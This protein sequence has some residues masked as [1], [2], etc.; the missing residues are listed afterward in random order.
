MD[1]GLRTQDSGLD[2]ALAI[3]LGG[4]RFRVAAV[5][6]EGRI[7]ERSDHLTQ[8]EAAPEVVIAE[9]SA[10]V[11]EISGR[12]GSAH[13]LGLG[14]AAPG[15]LDP[16][17]G[18]VYW[19]PNLP[20]WVN[21]PLTKL[22]SAATGLPV[23]VGNDANLAGFA[24]ARC[25]AGCGAMNLVYLTV[26]TGVG[27]GI[28]VNG[29]LLLGDKGAAAEAGHM[30]ISRDG[31]L[32][33][34]GNRGCLEAYASGTS[35]AKR[36]RE[37]IAVGRPTT[38]VAEGEGLDATHIAAAAEAGDSL[39]QELIADAGRALGLGV[40]NLLHLFNPS[41]VVI[42]G[43]VSH[44]GPRLW[45]PMMDVIAADTW[46]I[47]RQGLRVVPPDLGDDSGLIG[48]ALLVHEGRARFRAPRA[49]SRQ[50]GAER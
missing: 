16:D 25:G 34:C 20:L 45:D 49:A 13:I 43:G 41:V 15:P 27:S 17:A 44:I 4:T 50:R 10:A 26:S 29:Q 3:D 36:A 5:S 2:V 31:P 47:Y 21:V 28:V 46:D 48:A 38:L 8:A 1:S 30:A 14:V 42:G 37:A 7:L 23:V 9:L 6:P 12:V 32:C 11:A 18:I 33:S 22:L 24:E 35:L 39:A 40:R 19:A